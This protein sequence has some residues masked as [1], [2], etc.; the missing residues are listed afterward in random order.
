MA[1]TSK[2]QFGDSGEKVAARYLKNKG[3]TI[4][5]TN[6]QNKSGR[7]LGEIDIIAKDNT[8][9]E[10]VFVE[11]KTREMAKYQNTQPEENITYFK[12]KRL[13]KIA[14]YYL[15]QFSSKN[16]GYRFDA[17]SVWLD[18][19]AKRAKVKHIPNL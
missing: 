13:E 17:I 19:A 12:L 18:P 8:R 9:D 14:D 7:Q 6:F 11:V 3:Y 15:R 4:L 5:G 10:L 2:R 1:I 16:V